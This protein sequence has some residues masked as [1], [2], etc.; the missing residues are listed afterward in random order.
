VRAGTSVARAV[1]KKRL[2][3]VKL[4]SQEEVACDA[5]GT[6]AGWMPAIHLWSQARAPLKWDETS[7]AFRPQDSRPP[8]L[9]V[10]SA[11]G[12]S[13]L[14]AAFADAMSAVA[15]AWHAGKPTSCSSRGPQQEPLAEV[16]VPRESQRSDRHGSTTA[17]RHACRY[18][19]RAQNTIH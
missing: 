15:G 5:L 1:G 6:S 8:L 13:T 11:N 7:R 9:A 12:A 3:R 10:G 2:E 17:R 19:D 4:S 18:R 14:D 16:G